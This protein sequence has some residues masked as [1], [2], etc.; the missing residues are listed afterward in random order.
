MLFTKS[1]KKKKALFLYQNM[2]GHEKSGWIYYLQVIHI[3]H[4]YSILP[5]QFLLI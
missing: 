3:E 4:I 1:D 5:K 2:R